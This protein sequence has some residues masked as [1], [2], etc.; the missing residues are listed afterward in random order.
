MLEEDLIKQPFLKLYAK[1]KGNT[2]G[3]T[4]PHADERS[5]RDFAKGY[6]PCVSM[7]LKKKN[8]KV[9]IMLEED[10]IKQPFLKLYAKLKGNTNGIKKHMLTKV[11]HGILKN[12]CSVACR[13]AIQKNNKSSQHH[14]WKRISSSNHF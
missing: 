3:I 12:R 10:F 1:L 6:V 14:I 7:C 5:A 4:Q 8:N 11:G 9:K 2:N 13:C